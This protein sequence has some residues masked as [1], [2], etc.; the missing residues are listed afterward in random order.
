MGE[1]KR[2]SF[3]RPTKSYFWVQQRYGWC[4]SPWHA[5]RV[6]SPKSSLK[7]VVV[8]TFCEC[9]KYCCGGCIQ[10]SQ[11]SMC[12]PTVTSRFPYWGCRSDGT[13]KPWS[14]KSVI[15]WSNCFSPKTNEI[16]WS[17]SRLSTYVSGSLYLLQK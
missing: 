2:K 4:R 13:S 16:R 5:V 17:Q 1:R 11:K 9:F 12:W 8:A 6:L 14:A 15:R 3:C 7:K 10:D